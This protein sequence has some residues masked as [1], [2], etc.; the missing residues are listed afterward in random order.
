MSSP[1]SRSTTTN[2]YAPLTPPPAANQSNNTRRSI[3]TNEPHTELI[4]EEL[5]SSRVAVTIMQPSQVRPEQPE[6]VPISSRR[7]K[8]ISLRQPSAG[9]LACALSLGSV[10]PPELSSSRLESWRVIVF[11]IMQSLF[12]CRPVCNASR[13]IT[14]RPRAAPPICS[15]PRALARPGSNM[16]RLLRHSNHFVRLMRAEPPPSR[17]D[18]DGDGGGDE[19]QP[20]QQPKPPPDRTNTS[21]E[22]DETHTQSVT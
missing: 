22:N 17:V 20:H 19:P 2:C 6:L 9:S 15:S 8:T 1:L 16:H 18:D 13:P 14:P 11:V 5:D 10:S 7:V 12:A 21:D 3:I 4:V